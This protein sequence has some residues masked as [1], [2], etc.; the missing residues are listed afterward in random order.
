M[1]I[2]LYAQNGANKNASQRRLLPL[3][4]GSIM[5][6]GIVILDR[7]YGLDQPFAAF[8]TKQ[9]AVRFSDCNQNHTA[10]VF[11]ALDYNGTVGDWLEVQPTQSTTASLSYSID[12]RDVGGNGSACEIRIRRKT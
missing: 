8:T 12:I 11:V 9:F 10:L 3:A 6:L 4:S 1:T 5:D 7:Y 2:S